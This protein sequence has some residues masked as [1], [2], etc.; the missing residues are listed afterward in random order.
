MA[1][2]KANDVGKLNGLLFIAA[3]WKTNLTYFDYWYRVDFWPQEHIGLTLWCL[4]VT[5][6]TWQTPG[7]LTRLCTVP[8]NEILDGPK[9]RDTGALMFVGRIL[10]K[11]EWFG[12]INIEKTPG[13]KEVEFSKRRFR[14]SAGFDAFLSF[15]VR[16]K[17][18]GTPA[19]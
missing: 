15:D 19:H 4:S 3:F 13:K 16:I 14:K 5:A 10:H 6:D 9:D 7:T 2:L 12:L 11:L 18:P 8:I 17:R 1:L